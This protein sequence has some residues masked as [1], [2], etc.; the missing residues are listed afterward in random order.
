LHSSALPLP[1]CKL[2]ADALR[3]SLQA[4]AFVAITAHRLKF[5]RYF[6]PLPSSRGRDDRRVNC[7]SAVPGGVSLT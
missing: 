4:L 6:V 5:P 2:C 3:D 1:Y 7:S